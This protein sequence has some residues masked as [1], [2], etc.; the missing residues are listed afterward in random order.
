MEPTIYLFFKG[1]CLE[2]MTHYADTLG[3][4]VMGVMRN[5]DASPDQ[6]MPGGDDMVMN[7]AMQLGSAMVM[8]SDNSDEMYDRPQGFYIHIDTPSPAEF[9]RVHGALSD[10]AE[11]VAMAPGETFWADRFAMFRDRFGTPWMIS[12]TGSKAHQA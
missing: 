7:M 4:E 6:R 9:D 8:A 3:G 10:G 5:G 1:N 11:S 12:H 2:A